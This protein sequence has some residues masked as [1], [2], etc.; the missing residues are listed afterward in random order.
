LHSGIT[1]A[2]AIGRFAAEEIVT[3]ARNTLLKPYGPERFTNPN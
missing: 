2:P 3:G 1:L